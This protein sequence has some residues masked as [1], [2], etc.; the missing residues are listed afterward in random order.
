[1]IMLV[2][3]AKTG[4]ILGSST[5]P[6]FDANNLPNE[7]SYQS[8]IIS[9]A[10]EPGS[11]MKTYTY[12][13]ALE[14][15][16]YDGEELFKSGSYTV[17]PNTVYDWRK[18]GW[19]N[20]SYDKGYMYSSNA[21][22]MNI[23]K[24]YLSPDKLR[25]C[26]ISYGF[27]NLTGVELSGEAKGSIG[28]NGSIEIDW[29]SASYGQ[30]ISTTAIQQLQALSIIANDGVMVTPHIIKKTV[31]NKTGDETVTRVKKSGQIVSKDTTDKIKEL[32]YGTVNNSWA[33]GYTYHVE[34]FDVIGKTG[35]AQI[36]ENG[37]YLTG[38]NNYLIS[39]S[40]MYPNDNPEIIIYTA[41]KKPTTYLSRILATPVKEVI[42]NIAKYK[43][44]NTNEPAESTVDKYVL[45]SYL[46]QNVEMV[47]NSLT[48]SNIDV[49]VIG[50]GDTV[51]NQY[52]YK[53]STIVSNDKVFLITSN[54]NIILEDISGWSRSDFIK[55]MNIIGISYRVNGYGYIVNQN[56]KAGT[57]IT[58][59]MIVEVNL[60]NKYEIDG[61]KTEEDN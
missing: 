35:T 21:G 33:T 58:K 59:D 26:L 19:G 41:M 12:M 20:I 27:G 22:A 18:S 4:E 13:C 56:I 54:S 45:S 40:G 2:M 11:V 47:K 34:G 53:G 61:K 14:T 31:N 15:G 50:D 55:Y 10:Y 5:S 32:M 46:N 36:Y 48:K 17:G 37:R 44:I 52:P 16:L 23:S 28:F 1:M 3:D 29:L 7:M 30:G 24:K 49:I 51:V 9:Y 25:E 6:S 38:D 57:K 60:E 43:N 42:Q 8:P 39:F